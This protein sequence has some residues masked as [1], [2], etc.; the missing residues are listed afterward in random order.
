MTSEGIEREHP[1]TGEP[2]GEG[3]EGTPDGTEY[4]LTTEETVPVGDRSGSAPAIVDVHLPEPPE[5]HPVDDANFPLSEWA[6]P[7]ELGLSQ[8]VRLKDLGIGQL[9]ELAKERGVV[10]GRNGKVKPVALAKVSIGWITPPAY[11]HDDVVLDIERPARPR[12]SH[13]S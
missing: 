5:H 6:V 7:G 1:G 11:T 8:A 2:M 4:T 12:R 3:Q 13:R 9:K 10:L